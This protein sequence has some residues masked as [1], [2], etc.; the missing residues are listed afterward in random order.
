MVTFLA[1]PNTVLSA[2]EREKY[3]NIILEKGT[4]IENLL[5]DL[6]LA[7]RLK[8]HQLPMHLESV[9]L[10]TEIKTIL[11]DVLN[12]KFNELAF[13]LH[14]YSTRSPS[15]IGPKTVQESASESHSQRHCAQ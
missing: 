3:R 1:I 8:H 11:I 13:I 14:S 6:N 2:E 4:Y 12:T 5:N 7:M 9:D 15:V 10:I